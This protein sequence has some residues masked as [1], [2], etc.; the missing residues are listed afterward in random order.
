MRL[1]RFLV[2]SGMRQPISKIPAC[3]RY[4]PTCLPAVETKQSNLLDQEK[5]LEE[6][7]EIKQAVV[8]NAYDIKDFSHANQDIGSTGQRAAPSP[9]FVCKR[10]RFKGFTESTS[11][12]PFRRQMNR[13]NSVQNLLQSV[14]NITRL[15]RYSAD[16]KRA[17]VECNCNRDAKLVLHKAIAFKL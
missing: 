7:Q 13:Q 11:K 4:C 6:I 16:R 1:L 15:G 2:A 10:L 17:I 14:V 3:K 8:A 5:T 9:D 12:E